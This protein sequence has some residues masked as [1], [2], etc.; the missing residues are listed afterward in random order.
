MIISSG[1]FAVIITAGIVVTMA[2]PVVLLVLWIKDWRKDQL[3]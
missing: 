3:W 1:F 2:A